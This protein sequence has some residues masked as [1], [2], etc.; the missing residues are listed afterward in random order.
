MA[1]F[2]TTRVFWTYT[3]DNGETIPYRTMTG[4]STQVAT[5]GGSAWTGGAHQPKRYGLKPRSVLLPI[6]GSPGRFR[7]VTVFT[8]TAYNAITSGTT[9]VDHNLA[10]TATTATVES[11][12]GERHRG[13][14]LKY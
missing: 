8:P 6:D 14:G 9:T 3:S 10:G 13:A 1:A 2:D 11:K 7:R 4:Y 5:L 12:E